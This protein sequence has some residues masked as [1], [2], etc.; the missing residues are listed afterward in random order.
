MKKPVV[1]T[2]VAVVVLSA[3][4]YLIGLLPE[5]QRRLGLEREVA[6]LQSRVAEAEATGRICGLYTRLEGLIDVVGRQNYGQASESATAFF[7][8]VRAESE[9]TDQPAFREALLS[10]LGTRDSVTG[11]LT[12]A[13]PA[14][15]DQ[16]RQAAE[17]LRSV[18]ENRQLAPPP[19]PP[20]KAEET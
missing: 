11:S 4:A 10:V 7:D 9:R 17:L 18:L 14:A 19:A 12:R 16:L 3:F 6:A 8:A 5:R 2:V 13:D 1:I 15:L 20:A